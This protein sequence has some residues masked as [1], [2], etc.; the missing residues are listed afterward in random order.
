M[1]AANWG[2]APY[3][4]SSNVATQDSPLAGDGDVLRENAIV[5][6][7]FYK[8]LT[9]E[10]LSAIFD[11]TFGF[12]IGGA[13]GGGAFVAANVVSGIMVTAA[14]DFTWAGATRGS[15]KSEAHT[16]P[17]RATTHAAANTAQG[18]GIGLLL[19]GSLSVSAVYATLNLVVDS[20][21]YVAN[22]IVWAE[23]AP[24]QGAKTTPTASDTG[25]NAPPTVS[26]VARAGACAVAY[27]A[28]YA[29]MFSLQLMSH[30]AAPRSLLS[31]FFE[32]APVAAPPRQSRAA[33][34]D[35][36]S[37]RS[38]AEPHERTVRTERRAH[39]FRQDI[40]TWHS[41]H[42]IVHTGSVRGEPIGHRLVRRAPGN[43]AAKSNLAS[44]LSEPTAARSRV[45]IDWSSRDP[46]PGSTS[47]AAY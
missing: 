28:T 13:V 18:L 6:R 41:G 46:S 38:A 35:F 10:S 11:F 33:R 29:A 45:H 19:T 36:T 1:H 3:L 27:G 26:R 31:R 5:G 30:R 8:T 47:S 37:R 12:L 17:I 43:H 2:D 16:R 4:Q 7:T 15:A 20:V 23:A 39:D 40:P 32:A 24:R 34:G 22:D 14:H 42:R 25:A 9:Y 21:L 44:R